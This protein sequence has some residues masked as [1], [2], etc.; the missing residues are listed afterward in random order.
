MAQNLG[1]M[2]EDFTVNRKEFSLNILVD[3]CEGL[4]SAII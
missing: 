1:E 3:N 4:G 2:K